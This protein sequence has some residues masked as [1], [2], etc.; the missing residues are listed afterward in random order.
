MHAL[1]GGKLRCCYHAC[2]YDTV[3]HLAYLRAQRV[4]CLPVEEVQASIR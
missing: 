1:V 3:G 4:L 2:L